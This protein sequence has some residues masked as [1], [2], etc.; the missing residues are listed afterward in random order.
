MKN[1]NDEHM[2]LNTILIKFGHNWGIF[3]DV[4]RVF[5]II[6]IESGCTFDYE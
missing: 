4:G 3:S 5:T 2:Q 6:F 1:E